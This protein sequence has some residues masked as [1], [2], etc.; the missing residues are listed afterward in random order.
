MR[1][2]AFFRKVLA[3]IFFKEGIDPFVVNTL[4]GF[5]MVSESLNGVDHMIVTVVAVIHE[6]SGV[7]RVVSQFKVTEDVI[8][9]GVLNDAGD[10]TAKVKLAVDVVVAVQDVFL[11]QNACD[12]VGLLDQNLHDVSLPSGFVA[13]ILSRIKEN[14][15]CS[16]YPDSRLEEA[17]QNL[18]GRRQVSAPYPTG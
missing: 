18:A 15:N 12:L 16:R 3:Y 4:G 5:A 13:L 17:L 14:V 8:R 6:D 2:D 10:E 11:Y 9:F 1:V 7:R